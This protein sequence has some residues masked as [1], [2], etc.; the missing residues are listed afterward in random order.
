MRIISG[1]YGGR[2]LK[3]LD[4]DNTR[5]TTDKVKES[6]FNMIGPYFDGGICLDLFAGSG[7][8]AIEAVSRGMDQAILIEKHPKAIQVIQQNVEVT[9]APEKFQIIRTTANQYIDCFA[10][11]FQFD[12]VF[13]D[14]PYKLQEIEKQIAKLASKSMLSSNCEIICETD[15]KIVLGDISGFTIRK[16]QV[17]GTIAVVI[18]TKQ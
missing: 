16:R 8:L 15:A 6:M 17:Y 9:K 14:P 4:G 5:P 10:E 7:G 18:Y 11:N 12:L 13:F 2:R 1:E 3:A